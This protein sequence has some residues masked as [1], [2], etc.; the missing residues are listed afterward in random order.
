[1]G[2][3]SIRGTFLTDVNSDAYYKLLVQG[4]A[5]KAQPSEPTKE[6]PIPITLKK[7]EDYN[8]RVSEDVFMQI[9]EQEVLEESFE[10][11][12]GGNNLT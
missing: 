3:R 12:Y 2:R 7:D 4:S 10:E 6:E 9:K 11:S 8:Q 5:S 1:M